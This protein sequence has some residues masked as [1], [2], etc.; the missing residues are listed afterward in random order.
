MPDN[1]VRKKTIEY[2]IL[3]SSLL[4]ITIFVIEKINHRFWLNDF[5]VFYLAAKA[6]FNN[7]QVYGIPFGLDTGFYKYSPFTLIFFAPFTHL[8]YETAAII[9]FFIDAICVIAALVVINQIMSKFVFKDYKSSFLILFLTLLCVLN[10][11]V[12]ELHLGN[13]NMILL[14]LL[15]FSVKF[16]LESKYKIAGFFLA[17]VVLT[18]P[19]FLICILPLLLFR[20]YKTILNLFYSIVVCIALTFIVVGFERGKELYAQ[21]IYAMKEHSSYLYSNHTILS[22]LKKYFGIDVPAAYGI[23]LLGL[24]GIILF[25]FFWY[26][27][28][29]EIEV[30]KNPERKNFSL[31]LF[32]F[33]LIAIVPV[34]LV[35]DTEH[36]LFSLPLITIL[37][38]HLSRTKNYLLITVFTLVMFMY[39]GNSS[40]L[41]GKNLAHKFED[42]GFLGISNL[43]I[44]GSV[45]YMYIN[46]TTYGNISRTK[47]E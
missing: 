34:F 36:F 46:K 24:A 12:R 28:K 27:N 14:L 4:F 8:P 42:W 30:S 10:H 5:K 20:N 41:L 40:D 3:F 21:W 16:S 1:I 25:L 33:L 7:E 11:L 39:G 35:T 18:K 9:Y 26:S 47:A 44:I 43:I 13:T 31:L 15:S 32:Y 37:I 2:F 38:F 23:I 22:L 29:S 19:Y 6:M 45:I 17:I